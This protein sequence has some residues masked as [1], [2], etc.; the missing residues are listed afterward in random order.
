MYNN[1]LVVLL[2]EDNP[3]YAE[4]V[5]QAFMTRTHP[6]ELIVTATLQQTKQVLADRDVD[7]VVTDYRLSDGDGNSLLSIPP[8][9]RDY[10][11]VILTSFGDEQQAVE[12]IKAGALDYVIKSEA[13]LADMPSH[14]RS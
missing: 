11:I 8:T 1:R 14:C 12:A 9:K 10:P 2:V 3:D 4:L 13:I 5:R 7:I 6:V